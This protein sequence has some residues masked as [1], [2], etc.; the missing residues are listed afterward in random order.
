[1]TAMDIGCILSDFRIVTAD[2]DLL[3]VG[4]T[5]SD[6]YIL[7]LLALTV[8]DIHRRKRLVSLWT[9]LKD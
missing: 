2:V 8:F 9:A 6:R 7:W 5:E 3:A 4:H 1:M